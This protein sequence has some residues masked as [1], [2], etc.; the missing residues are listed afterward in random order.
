[1]MVCKGLRL[2]DQ[3]TSKRDLSGK[4]ALGEPKRIGKSVGTQSSLITIGNKASRLAASERRRQR[5]EKTGRSKLREFRASFRH[6][7]PSK[8]EAKERDSGE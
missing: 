7:Q 1:M 3:L 4:V 5:R 2:D 6:R 8:A